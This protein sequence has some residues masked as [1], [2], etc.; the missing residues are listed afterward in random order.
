MTH[1][2]QLAAARRRADEEEAV[3]IKALNAELL[4]C[5]FCRARADLHTIYTRHGSS[6]EYYVMCRDCFART[7]SHVDPAEA[8]SRWQRRAT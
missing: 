1:D 8:A 4:S 3:Q 7:D 2:Q 6:M 5:P